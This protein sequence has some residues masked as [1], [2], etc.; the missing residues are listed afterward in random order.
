MPVD[1][2]SIDIEL[3]LPEPTNA[4][5]ATVVCVDDDKLVYQ[6]G[7]AL[8]CTDRPRGSIFPHSILVISKGQT[9]SPSRPLR[10][11]G[12]VK[13]NLPEPCR[14]PEGMVMVPAA[15]RPMQ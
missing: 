11:C 8:N 14:L 4:D 6:P 9:N 15:V 13:T 12:N 7:S 1:V 5:A 2:E 3:G 10:N